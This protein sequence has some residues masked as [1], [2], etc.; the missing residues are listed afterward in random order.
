MAEKAAFDPQYLV[1]DLRAALMFFTRLP[2]P[3]GAPMEEGALARATWAAPVAGVVVGLIGALIYWIAWKLNLPPLPAAMLALAATVAPTG[4]PHE[5][6]LAD[7][8]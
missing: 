7:V 5:D 3:N 8:P 6:R 2:I 1:A 4:A